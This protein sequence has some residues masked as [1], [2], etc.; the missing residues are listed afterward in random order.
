MGDS[1][2]AVLAIPEANNCFEINSKIA[3]DSLTERVSS[4]PNTVRIVT[5]RMSSRP[6]TV[7]ERMS[8]QP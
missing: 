2:H 6:Y 5:E 8:S 4:Q 7:T 1:S 3:A